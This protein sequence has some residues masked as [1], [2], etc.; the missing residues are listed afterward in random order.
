MH[1]RCHLH[2]VK[3][4]FVQRLP[5][6]PP[7][8]PIR[9][10]RRLRSWLLVAGIQASERS[11]ISCAPCVG[12]S[13]SRNCFLDALSLRE[14]YSRRRLASIQWSLALTQP[15][16]F[17][18]TAQPANWLLGKLLG[19]R[20]GAYA[21]WVFSR[22]RV[23]SLELESRLPTAPQVAYVAYSSTMLALGSTCGRVFYPPQS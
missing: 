3:P 11:S 10:T 12:C 16:A 19:A 2:L 17:E 4:E 15:S 18:C 22:L 23:W 13:R 8:T 5:L 20:L 14:C 6:P 21:P 7:L 9:P 1:S